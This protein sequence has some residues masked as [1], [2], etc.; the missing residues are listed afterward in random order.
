MKQRYRL[1]PSE[2]TEYVHPMH[3][4]IFPKRTLSGWW[5]TST[6]RQVVMLFPARYYRWESQ[7]NVAEAY[8]LNLLKTRPMLRKLEQFRAMVLSVNQRYSRASNFCCTK[9]RWTD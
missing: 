3:G 4:V 8:F 5:P 7:N 2:L 1:V 6:L 9:F